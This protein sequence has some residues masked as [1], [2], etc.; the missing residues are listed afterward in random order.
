[1]LK[2]TEAEP[3]LIKKGDRGFDREDEAFSLNDKDAVRLIFLSGFS[4]K[5][6]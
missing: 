3:V 6:D 5:G 2:M 1:M 4:T